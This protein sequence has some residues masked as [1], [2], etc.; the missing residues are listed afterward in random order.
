[1]SGAAAPMETRPIRTR[2]VRGIRGGDDRVGLV[3][4]GALP[5]TASGPRHMTRTCSVSQGRIIHPVLRHGHGHRGARDATVLHCSFFSFLCHAT[6]CLIG[7]DGEY[8]SRTAGVSCPVTVSVCVNARAIAAVACWTLHRP[9][10]QVK[11][12]RP[13][14]PGLLGRCCCLATLSVPNDKSFR[15]FVFYISLLCI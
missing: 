12:R 8:A 1:V 15:L 10:R 5:D 6:L 7:L 14:P 3:A 2:A 4:A 9:A 11:I 13:V